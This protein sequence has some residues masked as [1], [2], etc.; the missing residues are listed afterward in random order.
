MNETEEL[1]REEMTAP[2]STLKDALLVAL[3]WSLA[4]VVGIWVMARI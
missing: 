2:A 3:C 4:A 1:Q